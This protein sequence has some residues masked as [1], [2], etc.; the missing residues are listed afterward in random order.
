MPHRERS[1]HRSPFYGRSGLS[2]TPRPWASGLVNLCCTSMKKVIALTGDNKQNLLALDLTQQLMENNKTT[3]TLRSEHSFIWSIVAVYVERSLGMNEIAQILNERPKLA[4]IDE[5]RFNEE[6]DEDIK[7]MHSTHSLRC[8]ISH[9]RI[10]IPVRG[11]KCTHLGCF[12]LEAY[13]LTV[14]QPSVVQQSSKSRCPICAL[15]LRFDDLRISEWHQRALLTLPLQST[16]VTI[17]GGGDVRKR[18]TD[19]LVAAST[20]PSKRLRI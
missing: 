20:R 17:D 13:V 9:Q 6:D 7:E 19:A 11:L 14:L 12:D 15:T 10:K 16:S 1:H 5:R 18:S 8:P 4:L 2:V 3:L